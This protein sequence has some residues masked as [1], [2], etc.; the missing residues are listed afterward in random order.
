ML[1]IIAGLTISISS[2]AQV[3]K[4]FMGK[5]SFEAPEAPDGYTYG[6]IEIKK[7]T[8]NTSFGNESYSFHSLWVKA[9]NDSLIY[10][11]VVDGTDVIFSLKIENESNINGNAV[12]S[13]GETRMILKKKK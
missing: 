1:I 3:R 8:V 4:S 5:W 6:V 13:D 10:N 2:N 12:W 7:D 9:N 11:S